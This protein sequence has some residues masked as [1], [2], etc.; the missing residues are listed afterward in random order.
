MFWLSMKMTEMFIVAVSSS[1]STTSYS[2]MHIGIQVGF[3]GLLGK[4]PYHA[5]D[6]RV[7]S[8]CKQMFFSTE[9]FSDLFYLLNE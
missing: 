2:E 6:K 9:Y 5:T 8:G 1:L 4:P 3:R 7:T